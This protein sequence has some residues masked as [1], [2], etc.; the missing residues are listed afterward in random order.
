MYLPSI[1]RSIKV[2][3]FRGDHG[4][5]KEIIRT[6]SPPVSILR[7]LYEHRR[8]LDS[9]GAIGARIGGDNKVYD[10]RGLDLE[11]VDFSLGFL[12]STQF[13][14][15]NLKNAWFVNAR[16]SGA[17]FDGS[18]LEGARFD[19][20]NMYVA[21]LIGSEH[22]GAS[23][24]GVEVGGIIWTEADAIARCAASDALYQERKNWTQAEWGHYA[25]QCTAVSGDK[26]RLDAA[27][28]R[29]LEAMTPK[30]LDFWRTKRMKMF[31]R[32]PLI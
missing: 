8:W 25:A 18:N 10:F 6:R 9:G 19:R 13:E 7:P 24:E 15:C 3:H 2:L 20:A 21:S 23:F 28:G 4:L 31:E 32:T 12:N 30:E 27:A 22:M 5:T 11:C 1:V 14:H 16:L 26:E 29:T 17:A